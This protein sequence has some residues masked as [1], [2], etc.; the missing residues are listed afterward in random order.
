MRPRPPIP[1]DGDGVAVN[2]E[3]FLTAEALEP[4]G[5]AE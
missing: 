5:I 1:T 2:R 4:A 3:R